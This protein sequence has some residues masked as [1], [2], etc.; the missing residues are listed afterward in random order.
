MATATSL[1]RTLPPL[2]DDLPLLSD[3]RRIAGDRSF[4]LHAERPQPEDAPAA[5]KEVGIPAAK[6]RPREK[7][8]KTPAAN[9][10]RCAR[11]VFLRH[12]FFRS[13]MH[14]YPI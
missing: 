5:K 8:E 12:P 14:Q 1:I 13:K 4:G 7:P 2:L 6:E 9:R 3:P 11:P 10:W